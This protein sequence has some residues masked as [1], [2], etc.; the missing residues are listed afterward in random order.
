MGRAESTTATRVVTL[1]ELS[2]EDEG[3]NKGG[4]TR[5]KNWE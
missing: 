2:L 5:T 1:H 3:L 4:A